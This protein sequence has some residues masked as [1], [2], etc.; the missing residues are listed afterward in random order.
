MEKKLVLMPLHI[1]DEDGDMVCIGYEEG[2]KNCFKDW[3]INS[4]RM[5]AAWNYCEGLP[6]ETLESGYFKT[7]LECKGC[8]GPCGRC[9]EFKID[10]LEAEN[11]ALRA[12]VK[13]M[14]LMLPAIDKAEDMGNGGVWATLTAGTVIATPNAYRYALENALA[15][16]EHNK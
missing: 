8:D 3:G 14:Q 10:A 12:A 5:V 2:D 13:E 15:K 6:I 11:A 7:E 16:I 1:E 4:R 9:Q